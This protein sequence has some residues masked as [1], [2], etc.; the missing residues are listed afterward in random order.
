MLNQEP[1]SSIL[2]DTASCIWAHKTL[3]QF[4][5][6]E[7]V[8]AVRFEQLC[9]DKAQVA[10]KVCSFL[11]IPYEKEMLTNRFEKNTSFKAGV[12]KDKVLS[13]QELFIIRVFALLFALIPYMLFKIT[14]L[15]MRSLRYF[16]AKPKRKCWGLEECGITLS[17]TVTS[18]INTPKRKAKS[19]GYR[20]RASK[21]WGVCTRRI[22][23]PSSSSLNVRSKPISD[24]RG[25]CKC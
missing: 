20:S 18:W 8:F 10:Q 9:S 24:R 11:N 5:K 2:S 15:S 4:R 23:T 14:Y 1:Y 13:R 3:N 21:I 6:R 17:S 22:Q 7:N 16:V 19:F 25:G 12:Q